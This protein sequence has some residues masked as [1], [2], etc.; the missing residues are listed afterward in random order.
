MYFTKDVYHHKAHIIKDNLSRSYK[1]WALNV[2][3]LNDGF[4]F[5]KDVNT[6]QKRLLFPCKAFT[7]SHYNECATTECQLK[8]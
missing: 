1:L 5:T 4:Y 3:F 7:M 8:T 6:T 2:K